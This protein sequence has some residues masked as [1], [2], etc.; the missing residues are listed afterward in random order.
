MAKFT[1]AEALDPSCP[2]AR[3][4]KQSVSCTCMERFAQILDSQEFPRL[5]LSDAPNDGRAKAERRP[6]GEG[7]CWSSCEVQRPPMFPKLRFQLWILSKCSRTED[8]PPSAEADIPCFERQA[9]MMM[10]MMMMTYSVF[11]ELGDESTAQ[12][13]FLQTFSARRPTSPQAPARQ[14]H[15]L[16]SWAESMPPSPLN[17]SAGKSVLVLCCTKCL[18][19]LVRRTAQTGG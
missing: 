13:S 7:G 5:Y 16:A 2:P 10:M 14:R 9:M 4:I 8:R 11:M 3:Q 1:R 17:L 15:G 6:A 19:L 12:V 18:E